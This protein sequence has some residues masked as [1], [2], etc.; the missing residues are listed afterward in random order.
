MK[1]NRGPFSRA[2]ALTLVGSLWLTPFTAFG[3]G[4]VGHTDMNQVAAERIPASMPKFLRTKSAVQKIAYLGS[5]P[6]RW[7]SESPS[8]LN[9]AQAP[10]HFIDLER[11]E[12]LG[13]L[14]LSRYDFYKLLYAKR[15]ATSAAD[16]PDDYLPDRV[17][18]QPYI[19]MEVYK[20]I[21][22]AF[23]AYRDMKQKK[24]KTDVIEGNIIFYMGWL[25]HYVADGS[26]PLHTSVQYDGWVGANPEGY[27]TQHGIH[28]EFETDFVN[29]VVPS[30]AS[31]E[32][33][34]NAPER[35]SDPFSDYMKYL[36]ASHTLVEQVYAFDKAKAYDGAGSPEA[37]KFVDQRLAA[38]TQM[39]VDLWYTAWLQ[40][41]EP[42]PQRPPRPAN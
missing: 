13:P 12:G 15:A 33:L 7:R 42:L 3:W 17:G 41:G 21:E 35:L 8:A 20:R 10:D 30:P 16:H 14:P 1:R 29:R 38:G 2:A 34:V 23:R 18:L 11:I 31:F 19:T 6:D 25:G 36:E 32:N 24:Q 5:E 28:A 22:L 27:T 26:Q 37:V 9:Y 4:N 40:S 39:L